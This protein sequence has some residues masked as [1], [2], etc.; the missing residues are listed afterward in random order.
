MTLTI[1]NKRNA[2][3]SKK[4]FLFNILSPT[5][6]IILTLCALPIYTPWVF[7]KDIKG[8]KDWAPNPLH[9]IINNSK[10]I[11][12]ENIASFQNVI[13]ATEPEDE[14]PIP[15]ERIWI[16]NGGLEKMNH[17]LL[18]FN[19][20]LRKDKPKVKGIFEKPGE[21][22]PL[23]ARINIRGTRANHQMVWKPSIKVRLKKNKTYEGFRDHIYIGPEDVIGIRN[24]LTAELGSKWNILNNL[25]DF[26]RV[27]INNK[28]FGLYNKVSPFNESFLIKSGRLP[29]PI[30]DFNIYNKQLFYVWKKKWYEPEV[31]KSTEK[32]YI[33]HKYLIN[34]PVN[35]A[36]EI[37]TWQPNSK[38]SVI[39]KITDLN[40]YISQEQFANYL[41]LLTHSGE[42]HYLSNHNALFW[43]NPSSGLMEPIINDQNGYGLSDHTSW[44]QNPVIKNEG[45]F[46]KVWFKNPL[47]QAIFIDKLSE[48]L[49]TIGTEKNIFQIIDNQWNEIRSI[50]QSETSLSYSCAG[51]RCFSPVNSLDK[52]VSDLKNNIGLRLDWLKKELNRDQAIIIDK[53]DSGFEIM[54]LGYSGIGVQRKDKANFNFSSAKYHSFY[55]S[56]SIKF[57]NIKKAM[58]LPTLSLLEK[59]VEEII[60]NNS[61]SF[62]HLSGRPSDYIFSHRLSGNEIKFNVSKNQYDIEKMK[63]MSGINYLN[64]LE[65]NTVP[66][67]LGPGKFRLI[68]SKVFAPGQPVIIKAGT[69]IYLD[70]NI[71]IIIQG[72]LIVEGSKHKPVT[73]K[74]T[75]P[76]EPFGVFAVLGS[77]TSGS[78]INYLNMEGGSV[79]KFYN[80]NFSG[81]LSVHDCPDIE[82]RNS[83]FGTNHIGDD[84]VHI[85]NSTATIAGSTFKN[86]KMDALDLDLVTGKLSNNQFINPGNDGLDLS[87]GNTNI[88]KNRF[89]G[90]KDKC[91]SI[92]EG[93]KAKINNSYFQNCNVAIAIKDKS[94][95]TLKN[96]TIDSCNIGWNSYRKK[97]R[98]EFGGEGKITNSKFINSKSADIAGDK[99]SK[100]TIEGKGSAKLKV[101]GEILVS[102]NPISKLQ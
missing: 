5:F 32:K 91:L 28:N 21:K 90:C 24:W 88:D 89:T 27:Y 92:G 81:M 69:E 65:K 54:V 95:A 55:S 18:L 73:I 23:E 101:N 56:N 82:I 41:A 85:I 38:Y 68:E 19:L 30:F 62:F 67:T 17:E 78:K 86:S 52:E 70:K 37:I 87:M 13:F 61:Y 102:S 12:Y 7:N 36:R 58:L 94:R 77:K 2:S 46:T 57:G 9:Y 25:E 29:G 84:A 44:I 8:E 100:V 71:Q 75:N 50:L 26:V 48:L 16:E 33:K 6:L 59:D 97:W 53:D 80:L 51:M 98:W 20:A 60:F 34:A 49:N 1:V 14:I 45:A 11:W 22:D 74:P 66:V 3:R 93:A 72:P 96:S 35:T 63:M 99:L 83:N 31:W 47:N 15:T 40:H 64:F 79:G 39:D 76:K 43:V 4:S 10:R 42:K